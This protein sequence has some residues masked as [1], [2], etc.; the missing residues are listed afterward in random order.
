[1]RL[2]VQYGQF[3]ISSRQLSLSLC[4]LKLVFILNYLLMIL[5]VRDL[6]Q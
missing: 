1:M 6:L 4:D 3:Y 2:Q 5:L